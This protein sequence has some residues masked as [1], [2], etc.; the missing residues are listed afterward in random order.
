MKPAA[1][2]V[3]ALSCIAV[4]AV[5][6]WQLDTATDPRVDPEANPQQS[7][8][9]RG[10]RTSQVEKPGSDASRIEVTGTGSTYT[11][12]ILDIDEKPVA[13]VELLLGA[14]PG[15][16]RLVTDAEGLCRFEPPTGGR[17]ELRVRATDPAWMLVDLLDRKQVETIQLPAKPDERIL[18]HL[19]RLRQL[20][21][22][23]IDE[24]GSAVAGAE[25]L[26][27]QPPGR[28]GSGPLSPHLRRDG[29]W[30]FL[31]G[32]EKSDEDGRFSLRVPET[33]QVS[34]VQARV[35]PGL[36]S[37]VDDLER[38]KLDPSREV[39][40]RLLRLA[41]IR[42]ELRIAGMDPPQVVSLILRRRLTAKTDY[43]PVRNLQPVNLIRVTTVNPF[44]F[45]HLLPGD[46][47]LEARYG[48]MGRLHPSQER[49]EF[50][51]TPAES[52][53]L[54]VTL[55]P[56]P[57]RRWDITG[58]V[59][60]ENGKP[61]ESMNITAFLAGESIPEGRPSGS[62][63]LFHSWR[64]S[65]ARGRFVIRA[66][67]GQ[68]LLLRTKRVAKH[69]APF[70]YHPI[71]EKEVTAGQKD[72]RLV[73][74]SRDAGVVQ[75]RFLFPDGKTPQPFPIRFYW[76]D[77]PG[78]HRSPGPQ[79]TFA[80]RH[81]PPGTH[82]IGVNDSAFPPLTKTIRVEAG[83]TTPVLLELGRLQSIRG[84]VVD[85]HNRPIPGVSI[86]INRGYYPGIRGQDALTDK[87]G[88]FEA[89]GF[90][91]RGSYV[92]VHKEGYAHETRLVKDPEDPRE[93]RFVLHP[94]AN[95]T[96]RHLPVKGEAFGLQFEQGTLYS[97]T[98]LF[99]EPVTGQ[100]RDIKAANYSV[101][102]PEISLF[103]VPAGDYKVLVQVL[104]PKWDRNKKPP[105]LW[106]RMRLE[107]GKTTS[108]DW[109]KLA[110]SR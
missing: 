13:G 95:A 90:R 89:A 97:I 40:L 67:K 38:W 17:Q 26:F 29:Y 35:A 20:S 54:V 12:S 22:R 52:K 19:H 9:E 55:R 108:V 91:P 21:G 110:E 51:L 48:S 25:I 62:R 57:L 45:D 78:V 66:Q 41:G 87:N 98:V 71:L 59:V 106:R 27:V 10:P 76:F 46:Y 23:V 100:Q 109:R 6:F 65:D 56:D 68:H 28:A 61:I 18:L 99:V 42:G 63:L 103:D 14:E 11:L 30:G 24:Q 36:A 92:V 44:A 7:S 96:I 43:E 70:T 47:K 93:T 74:Q 77:D 32:A 4:G 15:V 58:I 75:A 83:R 94:K 69:M 2:L 88:R 81:V 102:R 64:L 73:V 85:T 107:A 1:R 86:W 39:E 49:V 5:V 16:L 31:I 72:V 53:D 104:P 50:R 105:F 80:I 3:T 8:V 84:Q 101:D 33:T 79:G 60:G 37:E 82:K 34:G